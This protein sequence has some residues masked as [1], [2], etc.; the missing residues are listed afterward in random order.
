MSLRLTLP[1]LPSCTMF[2]SCARLTWGL[3]RGATHRAGV[4]IDCGVTPGHGHRPGPDRHTLRGTSSCRAAADVCVGAL[5][6]CRKENFPLP[7]CFLI[8]SLGVL[9]R[10]LRAS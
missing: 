5:L 9:A 4:A 3:L 8:P 6:N 1:G 2:S 7:H 10:T